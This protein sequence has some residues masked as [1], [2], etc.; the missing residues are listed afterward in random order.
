MD[1]NSDEQFLL[2]QAKIDAKKQ[3]TNEKLMKNDE[4]L[5]NLTENL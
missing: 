5:T 2:V 3:E 1:N 4:K